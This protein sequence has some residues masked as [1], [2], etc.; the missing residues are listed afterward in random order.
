[1]VDCY[2]NRSAQRHFYTHGCAS[3]ACEA[4]YNHIVHQITLINLSKM[5]CCHCSRAG[6]S[7]SVF[8]HS[9]QSTSQSL[10]KFTF[11]R[12]KKIYLL[13][14]NLTPP[15]KKLIYRSWFF[16]SYF[17]FSCHLL[18]TFSINFTPVSFSMVFHKSSS[19]IKFLLKLSYCSST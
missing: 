18:P 10:F 7:Y 17:L 19:A 11:G 4:V 13:G 6:S 3:A 15:Q 14:Q 1:M 5:S 12:F 16:F 2:V 9:S 8:Q